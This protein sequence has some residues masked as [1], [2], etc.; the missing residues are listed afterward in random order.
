M[1]RRVLGNSILCR[2]ASAC[3][4]LDR[5]RKNLHRQCHISRDPGSQDLNFGDRRLRSCRPRRRRHC[6]LGCQRSPQS[7]AFVSLADA[8]LSCRTLVDCGRYSPTLKS[9]CPQPRSLLA[10][11]EHCFYEQPAS[12]VPTGAGLRPDQKNFVRRRVLAP[13]RT[14]SPAV[15]PAAPAP[16]AATPPR[17][18]APR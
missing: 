10:I 7:A 2:V 12:P 17:S 14:R 8:M 11:A 5:R 4:R 15:P 6:L 18:R 16:R 3:P 1:H 9:S 13:P